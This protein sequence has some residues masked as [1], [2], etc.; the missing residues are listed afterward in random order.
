[1]STFKDKKEYE[2]F[3]KDNVMSTKQA[4]E[5]LNIGRS[6]MSYLVKNEKLIPFLDEPNVRLFSKREIERYKKERDG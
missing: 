5:Y 1:M 3:L 2:K 6:G 4:A